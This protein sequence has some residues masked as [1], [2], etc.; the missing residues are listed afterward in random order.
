ML[1]NMPTL[2]GR[3]R[4]F[5][6]QSLGLN[7]EKLLKLCKQRVKASGA[8]NAV[9]GTRSRCVRCMRGCNPKD[10]MRFVGYSKCRRTS[11]S[12]SCRFLSTGKMRTCMAGAMLNGMCYAYCLL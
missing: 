5:Y 6:D 3:L 10:R 8:G 7:R 11:K 9:L 4:F 12:S 1:R 2:C